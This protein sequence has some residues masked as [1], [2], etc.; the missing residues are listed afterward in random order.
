MSVDSDK[1]LNDEINTKIE[2]IQKIIDANIDSENLDDPFFDT[3]IDNRQSINN[4][5]KTI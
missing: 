1:M 2:N 5:S 3:K 4:L